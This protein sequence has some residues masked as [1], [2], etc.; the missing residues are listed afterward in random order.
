MIVAGII[1]FIIA[2]ILLI[3]GGTSDDEAIGKVCCAWCGFTFVLAFNCILPPFKDRNNE[4]FQV[5]TKNKVEV[6]KEV[7]IDNNNNNSDTTYYYVFRESDV[8]PIK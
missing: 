3:I 7:F 5:K 4:D 6:K 1:L 8:M 2:L